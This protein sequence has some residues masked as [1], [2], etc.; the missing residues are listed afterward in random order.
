MRKIIL[1]VIILTIT[2]GLYAQQDQKIQRNYMLVFDIKEYSAQVKDAMT[3]FFK[4]V[5]RPG[6]QL[7]VVT[8]TR[9]IG[10]SAQRLATMK[11][12]LIPGILDQL[13]NDISMAAVK[14]LTTMEEM[15][16]IAQSLSGVG[17]SSGL[18]VKE[19]L[20]TYGQHRQ[21]L[22]SLRQG[23]EAKLLSYIDVFRRVQG[24]N[25]L[26]MF[27]EQ[28]FRPIPDDKTMGNLRANASMAFDAAEVFVAEQYKYS[29]LDLQKLVA[30]F[31]Y[32]KVRFHFL[33]LQAKSNKT[34]RGVDYVE[35]SGDVYDVFTKLA[36]AT[37]GIR[38]TSS[39]TSAFV[40]QVDEVVEGKVEVEVVDET[41]GEE[42]EEG[43][44]ETKK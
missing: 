31:K 30:G 18:S 9:F 35:N 28:E 1:A 22:Q 21:S 2:M 8:P 16:R 7:I 15:Q 13:K 29:G 11:T 43:K 5:L 10:F 40:K 3:S 41:M 12:Q 44:E 19:S 37:G 20:V 39:K 6:D 42:N 26:L 14:Y 24:E 33:Y 23:L 17:S 32:A 34:R 27:F 25:H 4:E 38:T 36:K